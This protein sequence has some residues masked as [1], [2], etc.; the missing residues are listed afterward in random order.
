MKNKH[1]YNCMTTSK[2]NGCLKV[3]SIH[4]GFIP[5]GVAVYARHIEGV[6]NHAP[7]SIKSL[8]INSPAWPF[9]KTNAA[10]IDMDVLAI[11]NHGDFS[12]L[13]KTRAFIRKESPDIIMTHG[14]NGAFVA[15]LAA[16]GLHIPIV[17][18]WHG[19]YYPS[20][21]SQKIRKPFFDTLL[22]LLFRYVVK[23]II[24]VSNFSK[25][26]LVSKRIAT[27]KISV[28]HNGIPPEPLN[29]DY[30]QDIRNELRIQDGQL[31]VGTACR[32][33]SQKGLE[34]F[35]KAIAIVVKTHSNIKFVLWGDGPQK[36]YLLDLINDLGIREHITMPG[37]RSDIHHCLPA[38]D[39]FCMSS[40]AEYF[41][42]A[43]L[44]AMRSGIPIVATAVG[45]NPEA[46][47]SGKDAILIPPADPKALAEGIITLADNLE[48]RD[49]M[50]FNA[51]ERFLAEF[52]SEKMVAKTAD[53]LLNCA[54]K[55]VLKNTL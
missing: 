49:E 22:K 35:L 4:W 16:R 51:R 24:T 46:I 18:S 34:W 36:E 53:W 23:E 6:G 33:A 12:W 11:K 26:A 7:V 9:D 54:R 37:Y 50:A 41:S 40:Y 1:D 13:G 14:F 20:T 10:H 21:L 45:G 3:L 27:H 28:V 38:L 15:A 39:I 52:T 47:E 17:S 55:H 32:L 30:A 25:S 29:S 5:G 8:C 44:E 43:L 2:D 19:D 42:I 48:L 31:L